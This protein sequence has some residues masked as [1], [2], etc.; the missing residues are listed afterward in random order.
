MMRKPLSAKADRQMKAPRAAAKLGAESF[1][2]SGEMIGL[3]MRWIRKGQRVEEKLSEEVIMSKPATGSGLGLLDNGSPCL[4]SGCPW[5]SVKQ[6][7]GSSSCSDVFGE[8]V[9]SSLPEVLQSLSWGPQTAWSIFI[10]EFPLD[11][12]SPG[13]G[14]R[15]G[16]GKQGIVLVLR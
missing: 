6:V 3:E 8:H 16:L 4:H 1:S 10:L 12:C 9:S 13:Y 11:L 15:E 2:T 7:L 5:W 14:E